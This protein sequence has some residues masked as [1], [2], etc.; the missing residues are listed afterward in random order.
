MQLKEVFCP[1]KNKGH[2]FPNTTSCA[3]S[4]APEGTNTL[5]HPQKQPREWGGSSHPSR[6]PPAS[7]PASPARGMLQAPHPGDAPG[8]ASW[9]SP[10]TTSRGMLQEPHPGPRSVGAGS[11]PAGAP[12][13]GQVRL[14]GG[15]GTPRGRPAAAPPLPH[16]RCRR[17]GSRARRRAHGRCGAAGGDRLQPV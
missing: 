16:T 13:A 17:W 10:G 11:A 5:C 9:D 1:E 6:I 7:H 4:K 2:V 3:A 15:C 8:T 12:R 14:R